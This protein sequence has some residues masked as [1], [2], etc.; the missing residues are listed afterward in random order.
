MLLW[1]QHFVA[2]PAGS[3]KMRGGRTALYLNYHSVSPFYLVPSQD[4]HRQLSNLLI[5][6]HQLFWRRSSCTDLVY[7]T[8][9]LN[10]RISSMIGE[11]QADALRAVRLQSFDFDYWNIKRQRCWQRHQLRTL[12]SFCYGPWTLLLGSVGIH[13]KI[14]KQMCF[15]GLVDPR[16]WRLAFEFCMSTTRTGTNCTQRTPTSLYCW[17]VVQDWLT[18]VEA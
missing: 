10:L 3:H 4:C 8:C 16:L 18:G 11:N 13:I 2:L 7:T 1:T 9:L 6:V 12:P 15:R 17:Y 5:Q 14:L